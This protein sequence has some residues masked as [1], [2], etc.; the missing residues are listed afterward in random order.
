MRSWFPP[1]VVPLLS[2]EALGRQHVLVVTFR[3]FTSRGCFVPD[4]R[5]D[6]FAD[7]ADD[8]TGAVSSILVGQNNRTI[9]TGF[10][11]TIE[12][13]AGR[14]GCFAAGRRRGCVAAGR[15]RGTV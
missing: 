9:G 15:R 2:H 12:A 8:M 13:E 4:M 7:V 10:S 1:S 3:E 6:T 11:A 14:R 5:L